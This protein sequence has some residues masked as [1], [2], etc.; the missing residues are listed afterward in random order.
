MR[1]HAIKTETMLRKNVFYRSVYLLEVV[2]FFSK[3]IE[4][5]S[6]EDV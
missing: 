3:E 2:V 4:C 6:L 5:V 1:L